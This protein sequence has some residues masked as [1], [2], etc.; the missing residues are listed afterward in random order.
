MRPRIYL[1]TLQLRDHTEGGGGGEQNLGYSAAARALSIAPATGGAIVDTTP[2]EDPGTAPEK[3]ANGSNVFVCGFC[4]GVATAG[5]AP[6]TVPASALRPLHPGSDAVSH[7]FAV[8]ISSIA[9][10]PAPRL[11]ALLSLCLLGT[12]VDRREARSLSY[13]EFWREY[14]ER[15]EPVGTDVDRREARSLSYEE[16]WR[17]FM[18]RNEPVVI[19]GITD[20]WKAASEWVEVPRSDGNASA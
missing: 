8:T 18:E 11:V 3:Q 1:S 17:D 10:L 12:E 9:P 13:E 2:Q 4:K 19:S 5:T 16:F 20:G 15:N 6:N 14:M 7:K